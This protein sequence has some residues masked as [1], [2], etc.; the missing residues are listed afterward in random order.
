MIQTKHRPRRRWRQWREADARA[1][2][3]E[4]KASGMSIERFAQSKGY[5]PTRLRTWKQR[6]DAEPSVR[7]VPVDPNAWPGAMLEITVR[8]VVLRCVASAGT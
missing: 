5:A 8:G 1:A 2:L 7:F 3:D 6:L 4:W